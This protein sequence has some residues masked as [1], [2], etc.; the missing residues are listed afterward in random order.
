MAP[1]EGRMRRAAPE[2]AWRGV[3][4]Y[5]LVAGTSP[6]TSAGGL[7]HLRVAEAT[8]AENLP[9]L[10]ALPRRASACVLSIGNALSSVG[11]SE[12]LER[13]RGVVARVAHLDEHELVRVSPEC[14]R[15][16]GA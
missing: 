8:A 13:L 7:H 3:A 1:F 2:I 12:A 11:G 9:L 10:G 4:T 6:P 16:G 5:R 15:P 14:R